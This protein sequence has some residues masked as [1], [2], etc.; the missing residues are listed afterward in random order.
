MNDGSERNA[1]LWWTDLNMQGLVGLK[2]RTH[3][4]PVHSAKNILSAQT[5]AIFIDTEGNLPPLPP[6]SSDLLY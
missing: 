2:A 5:V 1:W 6:T 4:P 3:T